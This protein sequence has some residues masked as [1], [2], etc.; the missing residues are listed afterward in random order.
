VK[1]LSTPRVRIG[2]VADLVEDVLI[3]LASRRTR[4]ILMVVAVALSTGALQASAGISNQATSQIDADIAAST[5]DLV[6]VSVVPPSEQG[7]EDVVL[8]AKESTEH[9]LPDNT[10]DRLA[11]IDL[12]V[13]GG[14]RLDVSEA[15]SVEVARVRGG[16]SGGPGG[17][18]DLPDVVAVTSGY[19]RAARIDAPPHLSF[20]LDRR[21][22]VVLLGRS[23]ARMLGIAPSAYPTGVQVWIEGRAF[24]VVG[25]VESGEL[26]GA[27]VLPYWLG[28][29]MVGDDTFSSVLV[30]TRPGAGPQVARAVVVALR[31]DVPERL[32]ASQ[33]VSVDQLRRGVSTQMGNLAAWTGAVLLAL[34]TLLIANSMVVAVIART[35]EIGLRRALGFSRRYV[36]GVFL[37][38]GALIGVLGGLA[39]AA[40][41]SVAVVAAAAFNGWTAELSPFLVCV[42]PLFGVLVGLMASLYPSLR[43][44]AVSP[45]LA[46]RAD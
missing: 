36:A 44:A 13:E 6:S 39:G 42:G 15:K 24:D 22:P 28:V 7:G 45:A 12:V 34:T 8:G 31:P 32:A 43:A 27:V 26:D 4:A 23:A 41:S 17:I 11:G 19:L 2:S 14:R 21:D 18:D 20:F 5:I 35:A 1:R 30:R 40:L 38:E 46:V 29:E 10:E 16:Q 25:F 3:E 9:I 37:V 33:V